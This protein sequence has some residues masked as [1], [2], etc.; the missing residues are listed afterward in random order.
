MIDN[1]QCPVVPPDMK[2]FEQQGN[3]VILRPSI[4]TW[5]VLTREGFSLFQLCTGELTVEEIAEKLKVSTEAVL[6]CI[7]FLYEHRIL[8]EDS[9]SEPVSKELHAVWVHVTNAC[10]LSCITCYQSSGEPFAQEL[11]LNEI[12]DLFTQAALFRPQD[13][14][15]KAILTGGEPLLRPDF[16]KIC[17][18]GMDLGFKIRLLTNGTLITKEVAQDIKTHADEVQ[19]SLD[20]MRESNDVIRGKGSFQKIIAGISALMD[21]GVVPSVAVVATRANSEEIPALLE[22]LAEYGITSMQIRPLM[23][24]GRGSLNLRLAMT[25][26]EYELL[27]TRIYEMGYSS[28]TDFLKVERFV[29]NIRAPTKNA[30][31]CSAGWGAVSIA[32]TGEVYPCVAAHI[33]SLRLGSIREQPFKAI[34]MN[35]HNL[36]VWRSF[37]VNVSSH[38]RSCE[39]RNLCGGGCKVNAFL[40]SG[41]VDGGDQCCEAFK[42]LYHYT[43]LR[44]AA[45]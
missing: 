29:A 25:S 32:S 39:W 37:D 3:V 8:G 22:F 30:R 31:G 38:C 41:T 15:Q 43:L 27:I 26:R 24:R 19:V 10:N 21:A 4:P 36:D 35:S 6:E 14:L 42:N 17:Q 11:T 23:P 45:L 18:T 20:G 7:Q 28:R 13:R 5:V 44:E 2:V 34:W 40:L 1:N 9:P 12:T 33:P 16:W